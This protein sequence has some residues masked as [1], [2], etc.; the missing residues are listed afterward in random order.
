MA[1]QMHIGHYIKRIHS[2]ILR[3]I[4][5]VIFL[6]KFHSHFWNMIGAFFV[7]PPLFSHMNLSHE[8]SSRPSLPLLH[9]MGASCYSKTVP[10]R[11]AQLPELAEFASTSQHCA[12]LSHAPQCPFS[13]RDCLLRRSSNQGSSYPPAI[14]RQG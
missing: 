14:C 3:S 12:L 13:R 10:T 5:R 6:K 1:T 7:R 2:L 4:G 11:Y 8:Q 9:I